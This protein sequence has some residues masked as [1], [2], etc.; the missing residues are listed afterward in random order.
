MSTSCCDKKVVSYSSSYHRTVTDV[1]YWTSIRPEFRR[2]FCQSSALTRRKKPVSTY[3]SVCR[4]LCVEGILEL[5]TTMPLPIKT[6]LHCAY[7]I[8][9]AQQTFVEGV[10]TIQNGANKR[11]GSTAYS[12]DCHSIV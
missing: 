7:K 11:N 5:M 9:Y 4:L 3:Y 8:F 1:N 6:C 12:V 2:K 10:C